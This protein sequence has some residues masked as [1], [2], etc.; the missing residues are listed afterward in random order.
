MK[1]YC[2]TP[3]LWLWMLLLRLLL[4]VVVFL[5]AL[6]SVVVVVVVVV[7]LLRECVEF[8]LKIINV[9]FLNNSADVLCGGVVVREEGASGMPWERCSKCARSHAQR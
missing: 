3:A 9:H 5:L 1:S 8:S 2:A 4:V 7:L 6:L